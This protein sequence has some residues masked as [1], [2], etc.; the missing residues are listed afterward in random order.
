M[1]AFSCWLIP[2]KGCLFD[3]D[4]MTNDQMTRLCVF[5]VFQV[6]IK[7]CKKI[8]FPSAFENRNATVVPLQCRSHFAELFLSRYRDFIHL[9]SYIFHQTSTVPSRQ[10]RHLTYRFVGMLFFLKSIKK[11][12]FSDAFICKMVF[13]LLPLRQHKV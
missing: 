1:A 5:F 10:D 2:K 13:F 4:Q 8:F 6:S 9:P 12:T 11:N 3:F 7:K